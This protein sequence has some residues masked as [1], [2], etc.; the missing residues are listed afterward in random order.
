MWGH[1]LRLFG[2]GNLTG[3]IWKQKCMKWWACT[4]GSSQFNILAQCVP[5]FVCWEIWCQRN[6]RKYEDFPLQPN[7][8]LH[9]CVLWLRD[10]NSLIHPKKVSSFS[11]SHTLSSLSIPKLPV[12]IKLPILV[13]WNPPISSY[14]LN[15]DRATKGNLRTFGPGEI[16]REYSDGLV[17]AFSEHLRV[18]TNNYAEVYGLSHGLKLCYSLDIYNL[19]IEPD[20]LLLI[21]W[22]Q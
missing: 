12:R 10:I 18:Q 6:K 5:I 21:Q 1:A 17:V 16:I 4:K 19:H 13:K 14:K 8:V 15:T 11:D 7:N 3:L 9:K 22:I 2:V 20:S